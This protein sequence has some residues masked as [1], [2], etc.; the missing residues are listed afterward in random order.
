MSGFA[1]AITNGIGGRLIMGLDLSNMKAEPIAKRVDVWNWQSDPYL[2]G[3][4]LGDLLGS[5][6]KFDRL[7]RFAVSEGHDLR[8]PVLMRKGVSHKRLEVCGKEYL[9]Q[10]Y[11]FYQRDK[12]PKEKTQ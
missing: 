2:G 4:I 8:E 9:L 11:R 12:P 6:G 10:S 5:E 3:K 1:Q 7:A